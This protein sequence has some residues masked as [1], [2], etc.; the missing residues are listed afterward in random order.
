VEVIPV[1]SIAML[2]GGEQAAAYYLDRD[3]D[4]GARYYTDPRLDVGYWCGKGAAALGLTGPVDGHYRETIAGLLAGRLPDGTQIGRP[5]LRPDPRGLLP[6]APL[7]ESVTAQARRR[8]VAPA[9]LFGVPA[10]RDRFTV[11]AARS[12]TAV[13]RTTARLDAKTAG[14]LA[15][16]A[17]LD[18]VVVYRGADGADHYT[19]AMRYASR[20][21][22]HR[23]A[24]LDVTVSPPK[25][26]SVLA[27]LADEPVR[28]QI[29]FAHQ[30][31]VAEAV[32]FLERHAAHGLRGHQGDGQ[33][34]VRVGTNGFVAAA[35]T[36]H[37]SRADDPQLH[38]HLVIVNLLYGVD[39]KW[40]A[41]D[42]Q[43]L[44]RHA[45]TAGAVYQAC[46]RGQLTRRLGIEWGPVQRSVAE[47]AGIPD[48]V[49]RAFST[50]RKRIEQET[51]Q[52]GSGSR[53][54]RQ[55]AAYRTRPDKSHTDPDLLRARWRATVRDLGFDPDRLVRDSLGR[56][57]SV[58]VTELGNGLGKVAQELFGPDGL[59]ARQ[60]AF[61]RRDLTRELADRQPPGAPITTADL[62]RLTDKLLT[63]PNAIALEAPAPNGER[64]W[65][66]ADLLEAER[67]ALKHGRRQ[68]PARA[69]DAD[70]IARLVAA[71]PLTG[72]QQRAAV[73]LAVSRAA[74]Q[75]V[76]GPAGSGKTT[77]LATAADCWQTDGRPVLGA[78]L[79]ATTAE[80]LQNT[81]GITSQSLTRLLAAAERIDPAT[82]RM[83]GLPTGVVVVIDEASMIGT[84]QLVRLLDHVHTAGGSTVLIGD[85]A[86]LPEIEA[87]GLFTAF[88]KQPLITQVLGGNT[89]QTHEWERAALTALRAGAVGEA[90][91][92]YLDHDR[93]HVLATPDEL[94]AR[95][96]NDYTS[97]RAQH[98][99]YGVVALASRRSDVTLLNQ[100]IRQRLRTEG[101]I[102]PDA[103]TLD[104]SA[105]R[106]MQM[107][108]GDL[109][110]ITRNDAAAGLL[111]GT[112]AQLTAIDSN[113]L[114]LHTED[115]RDVTVSTGWASG[116]LTHAYAMTV[117]KAQGLTTQECLLYGT[118]ALCQQ[119]GYVALSRGRETNRI[120]T[121]LN[122]F[123][124][125]S[126]TPS[127]FQLLTGPD[128]ARVLDALAD[129]LTR[130]DTHTLASRQQPR[131]D[132][133]EIAR[134]LSAPDANRYAIER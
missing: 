112:R 121:T 120:Y 115:G 105:G 88:A 95:I 119:A 99:A 98:G 110:M 59:T 76:V 100:A 18:P 25:S 75:V 40:S 27:A 56:G 80:R 77:V 83:V 2:S 32:E 78:A 73:N 37:V 71:A 34:A 13:R 12:A 60:T 49:R 48:E 129:R 125:D 81:T 54:A 72:E 69:V 10:D 22:D 93:V 101:L 118:G 132:H 79:A 9:E 130:G 38:T 45:R 16:A 58:Q 36:H 14:A 64:Q 85:P 30:A 4:C 97:S 108:L 26:V 8:G 113:R 29:V 66:S 62:E 20:Q 96:A 124:R 87:G 94:S 128:P 61:V 52:T 3:A 117:H 46:L 57:V 50:Q 19:T 123:D 74:V 41:V 106:R 131:R 70:R 91:D 109:V 7:L 35:F 102:G 133:E 107:A 15:A 114:T 116:R 67:G 134:A 47:I 21:V 104:G 127:R 43:A 84:R 6:T 1:I 68:L 17:G 82:G 89:R 33:R 23:R 55:R 103:I 126:E 65:T 28:Q 39:G 51:E 122:S 24:G 11:L 92:H 63:H 86:Q 42:S 31:A 111:N 44:H 90:L 5:V 53:Q